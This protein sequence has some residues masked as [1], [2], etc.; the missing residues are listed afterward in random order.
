MNH[1]IYGACR[2]HINGINSVL[3]YSTRP[4]L[5]GLEYEVAAL[6]QKEE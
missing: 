6:S 4:T 3:D 1:V 2:K 5:I